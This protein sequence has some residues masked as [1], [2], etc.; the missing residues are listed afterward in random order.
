MELRAY[1]SYT[2]RSLSELAFWRSKHG[3]GVDF[4]IGEELAIE[5]KAANRTSH[6]DLKGL[7][8]LAEEGVF[9][10]FYLVSHDHSNRKHD[11]FHFVHW[12]TFLDE[13]WTGK[14]LPENM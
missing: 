12:E 2:G 1:L 3:M 11:T 13:L 10:K 5:V 8:A 6:R 4:L 9:K 7:N 14:L